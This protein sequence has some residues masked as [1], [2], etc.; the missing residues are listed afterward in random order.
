MRIADVDFPDP[1]LEAQE[2]DYLVVFA[3]AG[4]S[5]P[6]P[7]NF[8]D[9]DLLARQVAEGVLQRDKDEPVDRFLGRLVERGVKVHERVQKILSNPDSAPNSL[10]SNLLQL[11]ETPAKVRLVTTNFDLHFTSAAQPLLDTEKVETFSAPA[12]PLG[13]CFDGLVYLHGSIDKAADRLVLTDADFGRAYLTEGW[14]RRFLQRLF[15]RYVVMFVGYSHSDPVM[16]YLARGLPPGSGSPRRFSLVP[17]GDHERWRYLGIT[18]IT[19]PLTKDANPHSAV[20]VAL[21]GWV[22]L[23][24]AG[25]LEHER[26]IKSIVERPVPIDLE[27]LDYVGSVLRDA[28][29]ARFFTRYAKSTDWLR[30]VESKGFLKRLFEP[31]F[32]SEEIDIELAQWF[33]GAFVCEHPSDALAVVRRAGQCLSPI[34]WSAI[35]HHIHAKKP[36]PSPEILGQWIPILIGSLPTRG[37]HD[38]LDYMLHDSI[39]P[40]NETTCLLLFERLTRPA[41]ILVVDFWGAAEDESE[42]EKAQIELS[43]EGKYFWLLETWQKLLR[44]KLKNLADKLMLIVVSNLQ[45]AYLLLRASGK[46]G[47]TGDPLSWSRGMIESPAQGS[48]EDGLGI[49]I[50]V[51]RELLC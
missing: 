37:T 28:S 23:S 47:P 12:L 32:V 11:F 19:Y 15:A 43:T 51:A 22:E 9:F 13:D 20:G 10:H 50:D 24:R 27:E 17:E 38:F 35:A 18:P 6:Q 34:L 4:V 49:L 16:N 7:S 45:Q 14:A 3:G 39:L 33:A 5:M 41:V 8:P 2:K 21:A 46:E 29:T 26:E 25:A 48:P 40:E 31:V 30:W 1:L 44:L 42:H 36:R